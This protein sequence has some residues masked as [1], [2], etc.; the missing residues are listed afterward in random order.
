[1]ST[2]SKDSSPTMSGNNLRFERE[3]NSISGGS[4]YEGNHAFLRSL[5]DD[6]TPDPSMTVA[7]WADSYRILSGRAAVEAGRYRTSRTPY[8][9]EIMEN[10]SPSSPV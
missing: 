6:L 5:T 2:G 1:M 8:M 9:R 4:D 10:L 7:E 3:V